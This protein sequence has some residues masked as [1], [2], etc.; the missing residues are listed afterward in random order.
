[1]TEHST[2]TTKNLRL[3]NIYLL[4]NISTLILSA[5]SMITFNPYSIALS[6]LLLSS[7]NINSLNKLQDEYKTPILLSNI[8]SILALVLGIISI[9][10]LVRITQAFY[11][12]YTLH[13]TSKPKNTISGACW[14]YYIPII[15]LYRPINNL[16]EALNNNSKARLHPEIIRLIIFIVSGIITAWAVLAAYILM[17]D[18]TSFAFGL[19]FLFQAASG[20]QFWLVVSMIFNRQVN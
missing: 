11:T 15:N 9:Y 10:V 8:L 12:Y 2:Y 14:A 17:P 20:Y 16:N 5:I 13:S 19:L 7:Y 1:M 3:N 6:K 4:L 18:K